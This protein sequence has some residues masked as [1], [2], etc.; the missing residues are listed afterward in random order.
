M[1]T[2]AKILICGDTSTGSTGLG[3]YKRDL[4]RGLDSAGFKVAEFAHAGI[5]KNKKEVPWHYY[6]IAPE[7][8]NPE[9]NKAYGA[10]SENAH[11]KWRFE[12]C[13]LHFKP[14]VV[15]T[16]LDPWQMR[17]Q[18]YSCLKPFY[19]LIS[20]PTVDSY[21]V[22]PEYLDIFNQADTLITY[23]EFGLKSISDL[24]V[25]N[26][27][28]MGVDED[29]FIPVQNKKLHKQSMGL[30][31]ESLIFGFV[32]RNNPRKRFPELLEGFK[33]FL[34]KEP[35]LADKS[36]L[37]FHTTHPDKC[38]DF[39]TMLIQTGLYHKVYFSYKCMRTGRVFP[40]LFKDKV[41]ESPYGA[42]GNLDGRITNTI[43]INVAD[44]E[45]SRV[46]NLFDLYIHAASN[47][48]F[49]VP[50]I[51]AAACNVPIA[52][53]PYSAMLELG[54]DMSGIPIDFDLMNSHSTGA[55]V[56]HIKP[57]AICQAM[58]R[59]ANSPIKT[60]SRRVVLDKYTTK[61]FVER[62]IS[63]LESLKVKDL[64]GAPYRKTPEVTLNESQS[65]SEM[66]TILNKPFSYGWGWKSLND[67]RSL[68]LGIHP[69]NGGWKVTTPETMS[70]HK[71]LEY[72][73]FDKWEQIRVGMKSLEI[74][75][76]MI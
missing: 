29:S 27:I 20:S 65:F 30:A 40:S 33:L 73:D 74:E 2:K 72:T 75:Q 7:P 60:N 24:R 70:Y 62:W 32:A 15:I 37:Y 34:E 28:P 13:L 41:A 22:I 44:T 59:F 71:T 10:S 6:P 4:L 35:G 16:P 19:H 26:C 43:D 31:G 25:S 52:Y 36:F 17:C 58:V 3:R 12:K 57:D 49:G 69:A 14:N 46:Y 48:G 45:L 54:R 51:E 55:K 5:L 38:W 21:P 18:A 42:P 11:G 64:W 53:I 23:S 67:I 39:S 66:V 56:A 8:T 9:E 61:L 50:L 68:N 47:E 63:L 76:W 1:S